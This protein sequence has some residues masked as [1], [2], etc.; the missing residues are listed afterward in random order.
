MAAQS[1]ATY[2]KRFLIALGATF[3]I[4]AAVRLSLERIPAQLDSSDISA[5][6]LM[7]AV[8]LSLSVPGAAISAALFKTRPVLMVVF[9]QLLAAI[10]IAFVV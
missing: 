9:S 8:G 6:A 7:V 10:A 1:E 5:L 2:F 3:T 4:V